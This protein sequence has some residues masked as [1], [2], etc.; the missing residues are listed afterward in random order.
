MERP[1]ATDSHPPTDRG[2]SDSLL[3]ARLAEVALA[4]AGLA[5]LARGTFLL[6]LSGMEDLFAL[7]DR[8]QGRQ[9]DFIGASLLLSAGAL[10]GFV[11]GRRV[12]AL[13]I[14][15]PAIACGP[16]VLLIWSGGMAF[17]S[18]VV[19]A[20]PSFGAAVAASRRKSRVNRGDNPTPSSSDKPV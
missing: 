7:Q 19:L 12:L 20:L 1:P 4:A 8:T 15:L 3:P 13:V 14:C 11:L 2:K 18:L 10:A 16:Q 5:L 17:P 9:L 6:V